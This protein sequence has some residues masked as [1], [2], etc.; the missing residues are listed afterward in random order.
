MRT[1]PPKTAGSALQ[2]ELV[3]TDR[4]LMR[5]KMV[6][7]NMSLTREHCTQFLTQEPIKV[8]SQC[9]G[10]LTCHDRGLNVLPATT[11]TTAKMNEILEALT[12]IEPG[13]NYFT[14]ATAQ[15]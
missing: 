3:N 8:V 7:A 15:A 4:P 6:S 2:N 1:S 9:W 14:D 12:E 11:T 5:G 10:L 13:F